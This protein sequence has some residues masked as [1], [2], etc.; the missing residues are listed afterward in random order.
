VRCGGKDIRARATPKQ[1]LDGFQKTSQ[2]HRAQAGANSG[3]QNR[4]PKTGGPT[5]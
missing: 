4:Q 5:L 2:N 1:L 3:A